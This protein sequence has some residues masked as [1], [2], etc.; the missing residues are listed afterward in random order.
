[1]LPEEEF[2]RDYARS[3]I[4]RQQNPFRKLIKSFYVSRVVRHIDDKDPY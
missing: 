4:A 1:M 2:G 3:Q